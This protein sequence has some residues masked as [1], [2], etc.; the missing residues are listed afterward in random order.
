MNKAISKP[1]AT[2][3]QKKSAQS[4][5]S[6]KPHATAL[7]G[8]VPSQAPSRTTDEEVREAQAELDEKYVSELFLF[9]LIEQGEEAP[10]S[11]EI[12]ERV[13]A[14]VWTQPTGAPPSNAER[15]LKAVKRLQSSGAPITP[16]ALIQEL[17][18]QGADAEWHTSRDGQM[19]G[20][21][22]I[23]PGARQNPEFT[24]KLGEYLK[25]LDGGDSKKRS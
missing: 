18:Q 19:G 9:T 25:M 11:P 24:K 20:V 16:E 5:A 14:N 23:P 17:R 7:V 4:K 22:I 15:L 13:S 2:T 6:S 1:R 8:T 10:L 3:L 21:V 12:T